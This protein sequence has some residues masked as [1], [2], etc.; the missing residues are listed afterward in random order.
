MPK[1]SSY[2]YFQ[3]DAGRRKKTKNDINYCESPT[4]IKVFQISSALNH[5]QLNWGK[6]LFIMERLTSNCRKKTGEGGKYQCERD[7]SANLNL[8]V[9]K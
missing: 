9:C 2:K 8:I 3:A 7:L 5:V 6:G 1:S 4:V